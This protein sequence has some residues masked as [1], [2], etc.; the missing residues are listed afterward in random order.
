MLYLCYF[1]A[2]Y[3]CNLLNGLHFADTVTSRCKENAVSADTN[4]STHVCI[5]TMY[6]CMHVWDEFEVP[7][8]VAGDVT[9]ASLGLWIGLSLSATAAYHRGQVSVYSAPYTMVP[10]GP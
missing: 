2:S 6:L 10:G 9:Q 8:H 7:E 4:H 3:L 5:Y 1:F